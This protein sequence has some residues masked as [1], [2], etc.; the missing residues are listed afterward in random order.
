M[1]QVGKRLCSLGTVGVVLAVISALAGTAT[2]ARLLTGADI[3]NGS[4][5][6]KDVKDRSIAAVDLKPGALKA[7]PA[8]PLGQ[9]GPVGPRGPEGPEGADGSSGVVQTGGF[10]GSVGVVASGGTATFLAP[11][12]TVSV[13]SGQHLTASAAVELGISSGGPLSGA[14]GVFLCYKSVG[15]SA[16]EG[17]IGGQAIPEITTIRSSVAIAGTKVVGAGEMEVGVCV[18]NDT[19]QAFDDNGSVNGYVQVTE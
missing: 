12:A 5:T 6:G 11:R 15:S 18:N 9:T 16:V 2:A 1:K 14:V 8:G 13:A 19:G 4:L 17:V 10:S 3:K 7:G